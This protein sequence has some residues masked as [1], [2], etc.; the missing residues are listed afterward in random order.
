MSASF[1]LN[2]I[3]FLRFEIDRS[4]DKTFYHVILPDIKAIIYKRFVSMFIWFH[5]SNKYFLIVVKQSFL[6]NVFA[7]IFKEEVYSN[8]KPITVRGIST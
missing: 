1:Q 4:C 2:H 5:Q 6:V 8:F 7:F 3:N